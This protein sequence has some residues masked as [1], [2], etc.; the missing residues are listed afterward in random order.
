M[1]L[2]G[3]LIVVAENPAADLIETLSTA[4]AFPVVET[5]WSNAPTAFVAVKPNA[6]I[7]AEP[8]PPPSETSARMLCLQVSTASGPVIPV[9]AFTAGALDAAIPIALPIDA[10]LPLDRLI[11]RLSGA[12]RV[13]ALHVTVLRRIETY[14][15]DAGV[16]PPLPVGDALDDATVLIAGR[17]PTYPALS[18]AWGDRVKL[19]GALS[20]ETAAQ[21]LGARDIDGV[22]IA[23]GLNPR[24]VEGFLTVLAE[25]PRTRDIPIAIVGG[26]VPQSAS[27]MTNVDCIGGDASRVVYHMIPRVRLHAL[28][29]RLNRMLKALETDGMF[30]PETG[31]M[32]QDG[33]WREL[34]KAMAEAD[35]QSQALSVARIAL[36]GSLG[37]RAH[38]DSARLMTRLVRAADFAGRDD[39]DAILIAFTQTD[40]TDAH[41]IARRIAGALK[42]ALLMP[43]QPAITADVTLASMKA[44]DSVDSLM[45]RI[46]G[47]EAVAAQ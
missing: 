45:A 17:G 9:L 11:A 10:A 37:H 43:G 21:N 28:E 22:V 3:P 33:F 41:V 6:I 7:I 12:L 13:R 23:E 32:A 16:L 46:A 19:V 29:V 38:I 5:N 34:S 18:V 35:K 47:V 40:L 2:Q 15:T 27:A 44:Q 39:D 42:K 4:G 20:I 8:G 1:S 31:L 14:G 30:D 24:T 25:Q 36:K 26:T